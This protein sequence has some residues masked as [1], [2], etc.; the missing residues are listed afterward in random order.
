M[1]DQVLIEAEQKMAA[2][3]VPANQ[4][5]GSFPAPAMPAMGGVGGFPSMPLTPMAML[6]HA[7]ASNAGLAMVEK[8]MDLQDRHQRN[9]AIRAFNNAMADAKRDMP[10]IA[11]N[12]KVDFT[13][14]AG[15]RTF[16]E[17]EDLAGILAIVDPILGSHGLS[18]RFRTSTGPNMPIVVTCVISHRDG[19]SEENTLPGPRDD[20]GK[21][22]QL[23]QMGSTITYLQRYTLKAALGLASARDD[24]AV[25][26]GDDEPEERLSPVQLDQRI[27]EY[28]TKIRDAMTLDALN[29]LGPQISAE[30]KAVQDKLK[31]L[32]RL[33][34]ARLGGKV[35]APTN[36]NGK[37]KMHAPPP[38]ADAPAYKPGDAA[39]MKAVR[40]AFS[41]AG[42]IDALM[43]AWDAHI[44]PCKNQ[45]P[46][47]IFD[48]VMEG[49]ND[50]KIELEA[51]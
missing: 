49:F 36:G 41:K 34:V 20:S 19:Y 35:D 30:P 10:L 25:S 51:A 45:L 31:D 43:A 4:R 13:N 3:F 8:L 21:K 27:A 7:I 2:E 12:R 38:P 33:A 16:Y 17:Y 15:Q 1:T 5:E 26:T 29:E 47:V 11:K 28:T 22:N 40:A 18:V 14:N 46:D 24:D 23:Q 32:W 48:E 6:G 44:E 9:E 37:A 42:D 39:W 50:R